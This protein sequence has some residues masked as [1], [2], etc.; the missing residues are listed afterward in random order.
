MAYKEHIPALESLI[1][2]RGYFFAL[3]LCI[4]KYFLGKHSVSFLTHY[5]ITEYDSPQTN[6]PA[7]SQAEHPNPGGPEKNH[8]K[9]EPTID[10]TS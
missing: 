10:V 9:V 7:R 4:S 5:W 2:E 8:L 6:F 3:K 1:K